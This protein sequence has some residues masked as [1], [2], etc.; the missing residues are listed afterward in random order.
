MCIATCAH[1]D[2]VEYPLPERIAGCEALIIGSDTPRRSLS[3]IGMRSSLGGGSCATNSVT[4]PF[5]NVSFNSD[6]P[7]SSLM[8]DV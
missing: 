1:L 3:V 2:T 7:S 6:F 5:T 8:A 4:T